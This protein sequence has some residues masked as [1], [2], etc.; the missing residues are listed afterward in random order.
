MNTPTSIRAAALI[1]AVATSFA[2][3]QSVS[4]L[5]SLPPPH[6]EPL[7]AQAA[8]SLQPR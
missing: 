1:A 4:L 8:V 7:I 5:A 6:A 2:L 3:L